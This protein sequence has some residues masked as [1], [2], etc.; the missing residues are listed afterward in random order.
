MGREGKDWCTTYSLKSLKLTLEDILGY[1]KIER[2]CDIYKKKI[3]LITC[4]AP[5]RRNVLV[6]FPFFHYLKA[7]HKIEELPQWLVMYL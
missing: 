2:F 6:E 1:A 7:L 4:I 5:S 3:P